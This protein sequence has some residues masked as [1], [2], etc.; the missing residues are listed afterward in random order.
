MVDLWRDFWIRETGTGQQVAQLRDRYMMMM[1]MMMILN[2]EAQNHR[3]AKTQI[4]IS[5][6]PHISL[7]AYFSCMQ[8]VRIY[9]YE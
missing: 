6:E 8:N 2:Y 7:K 3:R 5:I 1:M 9:K 4:L